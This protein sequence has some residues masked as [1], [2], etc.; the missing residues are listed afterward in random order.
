MRHEP[1]G[2]GDDDRQADEEGGAGT[3]HAPRLGN[4]ACADGLADQ[5]RGLRRQ[6]AADHAA[7]VV[8]AEDTGRQFLGRLS[9]SVGP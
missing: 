1:A 5:R 3:D 2:D 6:L 9:L 7:D 4:V 8:G